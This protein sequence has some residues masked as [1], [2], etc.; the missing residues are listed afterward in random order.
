MLKSISMLSIALAFSSSAFAKTPDN[1]LSKEEQS[2]GW[3]L[4]FDGKDM[5][6]WRNFKS[7]TLSPKWTIDNGAMLLTKGG[8]DILTKKVY[9][10]FD[11]QIDWKISTKGNSGI[12][13]LADETGSMIYSH[14]PEIQIIDNE[15]HPDNKID[16]H[17]AGSL[18]DLFAAP[19]TA[20]KPANNWNSVRIRMQDKHLQVWQNGISTLSIVIGSTTWNTLVA[21]SKFA[22]WS[23]FAAAE[24][25]HIGLQDHG[26]KVWFKNIKI[27]EL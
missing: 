20:H 18:Y 5:S 22:T 25:G 23:N 17:L 16:S 19:T 3:Q 9:R 10:N 12:F 8:G 26:D 4:L 15:E 13:V 7:E 11:L 21:N 6:H 24:Q 27:K 1:Q 14:A 2:A